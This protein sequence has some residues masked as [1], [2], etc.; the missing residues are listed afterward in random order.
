MNWYRIGGYIWTGCAAAWLVLGITFDIAECYL[1]GLGCITAS[2]GFHR[3]A[4]DL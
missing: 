4:G 3:M 1:V 2:Y